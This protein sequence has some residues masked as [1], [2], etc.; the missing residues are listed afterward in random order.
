MEAAPGI[1]PGIRV[2]QT[3]ALPL[4]HAAKF[5][6]AYNNVKIRTIYFK[7]LIFF[8]LKNNKELRTVD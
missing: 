7:I 4:G 2:L 1:E 3:R 6:N 5:F 8:V